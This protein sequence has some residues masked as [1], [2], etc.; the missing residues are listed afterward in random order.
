MSPFLQ[1]LKRIK[2]SDRRGA[3]SVTE[4]KFTILFESQF[5]VG[6]NELVFQV[7]V[8]A[9]R[10]TGRR[11]GGQSTLALTY[12][13]WRSSSLALQLIP[14]TVGI[15]LLS[16]L[17]QRDVTLNINS[18]AHCDVT[19]TGLPSPTHT[20]EIYYLIRMVL[21]IVFSTILS[22]YIECCCFFAHRM[23]ISSTNN[24]VL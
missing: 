12:F 23:C 14:T 15:Y 5:S 18:Y 21:H 19:H 17:S 3:E 24:Y 8:R 22:E 16:S 2:R 11:E 9:H 7:K 4:E 1:S 10:H 20:V 6:G 13:L